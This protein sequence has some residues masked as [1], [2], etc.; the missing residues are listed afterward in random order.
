M[1]VHGM[2]I[3][4]V[5]LLIAADEKKEE[6][7]P[8]KDDRPYLGIEVDRAGPSIIAKVEKGTP[9]D[10]AGLKPGD[11]IVKVGDTMVRSARDVRDAVSKSKA[12]DKIKITV[13]R[14]GGGEKTVEV[15][16]GHRPKE[17]KKGEKKAE[18]KKDD[19]KAEDKKDD[20]KDDKKA[21]DKKDDKK[22]G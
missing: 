10:K 11:L 8:P 19:K 14:R 18:D 2:M 13:R 4:L 9:A 20:K 12:G 16:L 15:T 7:K 3:L 17:E 22:D 5:G 6:I 21:E 1:K